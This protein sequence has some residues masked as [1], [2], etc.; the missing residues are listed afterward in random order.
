MR[1]E[2]K[3]FF[4]TNITVKYANRIGYA[5]ENTKKLLDII[6]QSKI[7]SKINQ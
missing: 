6:Y 1:K 4:S 2:K 5:G 7:F 3:N